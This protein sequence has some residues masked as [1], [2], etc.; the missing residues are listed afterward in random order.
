[1][2]MLGFAACKEGGT[3][4]VTVPIPEPGPYQALVRM[5]ACGVCNGTDSKIIHHT[6]KLFDQY[7][8]LLG[9]EGVGEVVR[10]G[11]KARTL[12]LGDRVLLPF[13]E[14]DLGGY[15][16]GWGAYC[17]YAVVWD[18]QSM[19]ADGLTPPDSAYA[20]SVLP[21]EMDPVDATM[22]VTFREV[23]SSL[24]R[25]GIQPGENV[26]VYGAGPVG[27]CFI[28]FL[29]RRGC[30]VISVDITDEKAQRAQ[31][32]GADW[33]INSTRTDVVSF[34]RERFPDGAQSVVD[35]VGVNALINQAM[36]LIANHGKICSYGISPKLGME[37]DWSRAPYNWSV[38]FVQ[39]PEKTEEAAMHPEVMQM[40]AEGYLV[41]RDFISLVLPL[42]EIGTAFDLV[43]KKQTDLKTV[44]AFAD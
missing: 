34:V 6:F 3:A 9:H 22:I 11:E 37:I 10:L 44:I 7:P 25:F 27:L 13:I 14:G 40:I 21:P 39:F 36:E 2:T 23:L 18:A 42:N 29:K 16:S 38:N 8:T 28:K 1:M 33:A 35:A 17:E 26:V 19:L 12:R 15:S 5:K 24:P 41:P 32:F 30:T 31:A 4:L 43:E 20:Q